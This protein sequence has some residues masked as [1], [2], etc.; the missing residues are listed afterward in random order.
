M[1]RWQ[2]ESGFTFTK[3]DKSEFKTFGEF[4]LRY[5]LHE[6]VELRM[7]N[8]SYGRANVAGG[9][10]SGWLDPVVGVKYRFHTG[11]TGKSPDLALVAQTS[12]PMGDRDFQIDAHQPTLKFAGYYQADTDDGFGWNVVWSRLGSD[13]TDFDQWAFGGYWSRTVN[14][15]TGAFAEIYH[16]TPD[17]NGGPDAT[18]ADFGLVY[19]LD[20]A[21]QVNVRVGSGFDQQ[22]D[23]WF[24]GAGIGFRF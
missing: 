6:R 15:K 5:P 9:G 16:L 7:S 21:T 3:E 14:A 13:P 10:G 8:L 12:L 18:Y 24:V 4:L 20:K 19:L 22:R 11:V 1:G 2:I 23:G 17:S